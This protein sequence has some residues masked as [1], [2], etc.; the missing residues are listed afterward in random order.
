MTVVF[1]TPSTGII[2]LEEAGQS[3]KEK[4]R[5]WWIFGVVTGATRCAGEVL[6]EPPETPLD[7]R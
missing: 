7:R 6:D 4:V 5:S 2:V 1:D 3:V